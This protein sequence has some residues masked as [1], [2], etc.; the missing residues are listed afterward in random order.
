MNRDKS[1]VM[2]TALGIAAAVVLLAFSLAVQPYA[3]SATAQANT[4]T[5]MP[6]TSPTNVPRTHDTIFAEIESKLPGFAGMFLD[7]EG[8]LNI[9]LTNPNAVGTA[10]ISTILAD[11]VEQ[12]HLE[13]GITMLQA[14]HSWDEW[15]AWKQTLRE[16]LPQKE[17]GVTTLDIDEKNQKLVI[18]FAELNDTVQSQ[19]SEFLRIKGIPANV[20]Q[21]IET[22]PVIDESHGDPVSPEKGGMEIGWSVGTDDYVCTNGFI[23]DRQ[24]DDLRVSVTAGH[25]EDGI[26]TAGDQSY[27]QP[28]GGT[29]VGTEVANT[30]LAVPR[31]SDS[32]LWEPALG[33]T[34][35]L[36]KIY[37]DSTFDYTITGK[38]TSA[39]LVG[40]LL[41]KTGRTTHETSGAITGTCVDYN[42]PSH[43]G[44]IYCVNQAAYSSSG[45][46]SGSP[47]FK[48]GTSPNVTLYG[49]HHSRVGSVAIY[50]PIANI[51][52]DQGT[53][54]V[55]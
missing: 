21:L 51:E 55:N 24:S 18:G 45:G 2:T 15:V 32:L 6:P 43:G 17:L 52:I 4:N 35:S 42:S 7:E 16:L 41:Y 8:K 37:K 26:D 39:Q 9:Y 31:Y 19:V 47:V 1:K 50:S 30:N 23:A 48:K 49:L 38:K 34:T 53:L 12:E 10:Q 28:S 36:G 22:G 25:C 14:N 27:D 20:V 11:Y 54:T 44:A 29:T 3:P 46:D 40:E 5:S 33:V 13:K